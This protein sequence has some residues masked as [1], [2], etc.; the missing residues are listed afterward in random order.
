M[1]PLLNG[2]M[3]MVTDEI[4]IDN[5]YKHTKDHHLYKSELGWSDRDLADARSDD[6]ETVFRYH[7]EE[8]GFSLSLFWID[9][10]E[11]YI[12]DTEKFPIE[13]RK[14]GYNPGWDGKYE[15]QK[16]I[17]CGDHHADGEI[18]YTFDDV[19]EIWDDLVINGKHLI[20]II[21]RSVIL[22]IG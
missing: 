18:L 12:I 11:V 6:P 13:V 8:V 1:K 10:R 3:N 9:Y 16:F 5:F 22:D 21:P 19:S 17:M 20:D 14:C 15:Y 7:V 2:I 4:L